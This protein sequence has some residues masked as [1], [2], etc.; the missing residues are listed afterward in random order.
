MA[1]NGSTFGLRLR[2]AIERM[3][4]DGRR[5]GVARFADL[6]RKRAKQ[7]AAEGRTLPGVQISTIHGYLKDEIQASVI[8]HEEAARLLNVCPG[9]L[10]HGLGVPEG[11]P[12]AGEGAP[13]PVPEESLLESAARDIGL[14]APTRAV[15]SDVWQRHIDGARENFASPF[16]TYQ[17]ANDLLR[18]LNLPDQ[19]WGL[20]HD[21]SVS[22]RNNYARAILNALMLVMPAK[23]QGDWNVDRGTCYAISIELPRDLHR[24]A[25]IAMDR[26]AQRNKDAKAVEARKANFD[27]K[28]AAAWEMIPVLQEAGLTNAEILERLRLMADRLIRELQ[29][30][31]DANE[32]RRVAAEPEHQGGDDGTD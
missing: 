23:G 5:R 25:E 7:L 16:E 29:G 28:S 8:F 1:D 24:A 6:M 9:W 11:P 21:L 27:E 13:A 4:R 3:P 12:A 10:T 20:R 14:D 32:E 18:L 2:W 26:A 30:G 19:Y 31:Q 22:E 17:F 15:L